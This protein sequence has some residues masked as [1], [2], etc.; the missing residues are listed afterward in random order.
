MVEFGTE[1]VCNTNLESNYTI[2]VI[3]VRWADQTAEVLR[4]K[5][6]GFL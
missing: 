1:K 2:G 6:G 4:W 5:G 3:A